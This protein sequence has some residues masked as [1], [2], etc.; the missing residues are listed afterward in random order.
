MTTFGDPP[1]LLFHSLQ[2]GTHRF[3]PRNP[4]SDFDFSEGDE[5]FNSSYAKVRVRD[6]A[7][8]LGS[9]CTGWCWRVY[10]GCVAPG[11]C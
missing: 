2:R 1:F 8:A 11:G 6:C 10:G 4:I 5:V 3:K 7:L 9:R